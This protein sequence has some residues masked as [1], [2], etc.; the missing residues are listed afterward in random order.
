MSRAEARALTN[1]HVRQREASDASPER[2]PRGLNRTL[3]NR[4]GGL[5]VRSFFC[6]GAAAGDD[7]LPAFTAGL[8]WADTNGNLIQG[9]NGSILKPYGSS[10]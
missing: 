4:A 5:S 9:R 3:R 2:P 8:P 10:T 1:L 7:L 6:F